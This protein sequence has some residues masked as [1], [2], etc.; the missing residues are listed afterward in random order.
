MGSSTFPEVSCRICGKSIDL[1]VDV[2]TD[3]GGRAVHEDCY[4][5]QIGQSQMRALRMQW[6]NSGLYV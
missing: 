2:H 5:K 4:L 6:Q 1:C 3:E